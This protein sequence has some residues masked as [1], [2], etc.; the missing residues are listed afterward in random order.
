[1]DRGI[2]GGMDGR[3]D[4]RLDGKRHTL[5]CREQATRFVSLVDR[6]DVLYYKFDEYRPGTP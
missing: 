5:R 1:M 6:K 3:M 4:G 2:D